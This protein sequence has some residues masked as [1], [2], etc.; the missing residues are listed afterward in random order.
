M[1]GFL[2]ESPLFAAEVCGMPVHK[3]YDDDFSNQHP[4]SHSTKIALETGVDYF[5][6]GW[7]NT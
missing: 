4:A 5:H 6:N 7:A 3:W 1:Q 2:V